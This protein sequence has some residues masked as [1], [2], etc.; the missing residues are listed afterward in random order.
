MLDSASYTKGPQYILGCKFVISV[1]SF[2]TVHSYKI[3][4]PVLNPFLNCGNR[5]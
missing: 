2:N 3:R 1:F 4:F 5:V